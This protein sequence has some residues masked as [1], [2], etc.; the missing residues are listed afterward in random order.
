MAT[1][2]VPGIFGVSLYIND[3]WTP[4]ASFTNRPRFPVQKCYETIGNGPFSADRYDE[5]AYTEKNRSD[6]VKSIRNKTRTI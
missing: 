1:K 3:R 2:S 4:V 6:R 5:D